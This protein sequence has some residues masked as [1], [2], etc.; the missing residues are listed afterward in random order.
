MQFN[1]MSEHMAAAVVSVYPSP[2]HLLSV[3]HTPHILL[4]YTQTTYMYVCFGVGPRLTHHGIYTACNVSFA[5][6]RLHLT[7]TFA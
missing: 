6:L 5:T 7:F 3:S 2:A 1:N 4:Y